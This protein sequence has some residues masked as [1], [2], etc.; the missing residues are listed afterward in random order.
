[1]RNPHPEAFSSRGRDDRSPSTKLGTTPFNRKITVQQP[2]AGHGLT[3]NSRRLAVTYQPKG[4][5]R[6]LGISSEQ[7]ADAGVAIRVPTS[8]QQAASGGELYVESAPK[9]HTLVVG[10]SVS[11]SIRFQSQGA[12]PALGR[13]T[14][15]SS[16][17]QS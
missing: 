14:T 1:M 2:S 17:N 12:V 5:R 8:P 3:I 11:R 6:Q 13:I 16:S 4:N 10:R 7:R 15:Q 9:Q